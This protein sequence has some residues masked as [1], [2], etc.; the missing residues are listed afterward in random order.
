MLGDELN[1]G[2]DGAQYAARTG[3]APLFKIPLD[4]VNIVEGSRPTP[5][6]ER[7]GVTGMAL[8]A[9]ADTPIEAGTQ[10]VVISV[11]VTFLIGAAPARS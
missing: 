3:R 10:E 1:A 2:I 8:K 9:A 6:F 11:E 7:G 5:M 4:G